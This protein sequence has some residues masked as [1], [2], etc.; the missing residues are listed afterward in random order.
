MNKIALI[1]KGLKSEFNRI[2]FPSTDKLLK[3]SVKVLITSII[4]GLLIFG[5]D[6]IISYAFSFV[7]G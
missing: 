2:I 4:V 3:D 5:L 7:L 1:F 6:S